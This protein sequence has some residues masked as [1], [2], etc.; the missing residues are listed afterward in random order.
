ML[1][2]GASIAGP[3]L[4]FWLHHFGHAVTVVESAPAVRAGGYPIDL[5]GAAIEVVRRMGLY[6]DLRAAHVDI[7]RMTYVDATGRAIAVIRPEAVTGG[8]EGRDLEVPRGALTSA[9]YAHTREDVE[10][11]FGESIA[12]LDDRGDAVDV[13]FT[14]GGRRRFDLVI[15]ADGLHSNVR[16]LVFGHEERYSHYLGHTFVGF[17]APN[18]LRLSSE[19]MAHNT[20]GRMI[21]LYA[22][23][24]PDTVHAFFAHHRPE[25]SREE[26]RDLDGQVRGTVEL[27]ASAGWEAPRLLDELQRADDVFADAVAQIRMPSWS[28]GRVALVGDAA[29]APSFLSGQGTSLAVVGA[30]VL[31]GELA[32]TADHTAAFAGYERRMRGFVGRN[33]QLA[34]GLGARCVLPGTRPGLWVRN[35]FVRAQPLLARTGVGRGGAAATTAIDLPGYDIAPATDLR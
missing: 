24:E 12:A 4:A 30:Y 19:G 31:A 25:P 10:Y 34:F 2:S 13:T 3:A 32:T 20:P 6:D 23:K 5:R 1:I 26:L 22:T 33:Q 28:A 29:Y 11:L 7:R 15:G 18:H 16:E 21:A 35:A 27:F 9:L 14:G 17:T 8:V